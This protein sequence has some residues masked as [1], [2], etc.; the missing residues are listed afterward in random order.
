MTGPGRVRDPVDVGRE[1]PARSPSARCSASRLGASSP[2]TSDR[3]AI[4]RV[5]RHQRDRVAPRPVGQPP[6]DQHRREVVGERRAAEGGGQEPGEGHAD[7]HRGQE[8]VGSS[9]SSGDPGAAPAAL[10]MP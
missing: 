3:Y 2:S 7:L 10:G 4:T 8:A 6:V 1:R 9:C 5:T